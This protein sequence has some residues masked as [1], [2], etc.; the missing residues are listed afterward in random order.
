MIGA[1]PKEKEKT[2]YSSKLIAARIIGNSENK[3]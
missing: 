2:A 3:G 1:T